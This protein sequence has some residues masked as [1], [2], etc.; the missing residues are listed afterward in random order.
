[1][2]RSFFA[3]NLP[4][5]FGDCAVDNPPNTN[6]PSNTGAQADHRLAWERPVLR[7]LDAMSAQNQDSGNQND[8]SASGNHHRS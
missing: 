8:G 5:H 3:A 1:L 7:R 2:W 4:L 6:E